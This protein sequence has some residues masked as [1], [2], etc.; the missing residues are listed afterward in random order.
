MFRS[1][2]SPFQ[3]RGTL[4]LLLVALIMTLF[5]SASPVFADGLP[6]ALL[7]VPT[8]T[9]VG[10]PYTFTVAFDNDNTATV[11][12][13]PYID[14]ALPAAGAD[15]AGAQLDDGITFTSAAYLG[16]PV[17]PVIPPF[18]CTGNFTHPL[19]GLV[20]ACVVDTQIVI[21]QPPYGS[22][23]PTQPP[24][25]LEIKTDL[26]NLADVGTPLT[27]RAS[28]GF[29]LGNDP[30]DNPVSDPPI[31]Q[32]TTATASVTPILWTLTKTY[33]GPESE[34]ATGPNFP[35]QYR[36]DIDIATG[37]VINNLDITDLLPPSMQFIGVDSVTTATGSPT[38]TD[39]ATPST[40]TPGGTL[41]R[42]LSSAAGTAGVQDAS[43]IFSFFVPRLDAAS[44]VI[45]PDVSGDDALGINDAQA[46]G[47]W[48]TADGRD[49][50]AVVAN[51]VTPTDHTLEEQSIA[52]QK[53]ANNR[54]DAVTSPGDL[55]QYTLDVQVSDYFAFQ[56]VR[57]DDTLGDGL[58]FDDS[59]PPT[60][61]CSEHGTTSTG[62][63][64]VANYTVADNWTDVNG[65]ALPNPG[66]PAPPHTLDPAANNGTTKLTFR[67]S[68]QLV[69]LG[70]N[71]QLVGGGIPNGGTGAGPLSNNP[72]LPF[73]PTTCQ[74]TYRATI[75]DRFTDVF[76]SNDFSID[77]GDILVNTAIVD[78]AV[79]AASNL[80]PT[81]QRED[82]DTAATISIARGDLSKTIYAINGDTA[83]LPGNCNGASETVLAPGE[84]VTYR[85]RLSL[86]TSDI[87]KLR[88]SDF[89]PLPIFNVNDNTA[90]IVSA[91]TTFDTT[92][93]PAPPPAGTAKFGPTDNFFAESGIQPNVIIDSLA[94]SVTFDY[95]NYDD[96]NNTPNQIDI[97]FTVTASYAPFDDKLLLTNLVREQETSTN[98]GPQVR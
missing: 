4:V 36:I 7:V 98:A 58:R 26:S 25:V 39:L 34:T 72:L 33:I 5:G 19:T 92:V 88:L 9:F 45:L 53:S 40:S 71:G 23:T 11:G 38:V 75:E 35:R 74:I 13:G 48:D 77:Q 89:L 96:V 97:L 43:L 91:I 27:I 12:Y 20:T 41:T 68:D 95:D 55:Y 42:R 85:L 2:P 18:L 1:I 22:F 80:V 15:G 82:D 84:T 60:L 57:V 65:A 46:N 37:Q 86:P 83:C 28:S 59:F 49:L 47:T 66:T 61:S 14:L 29:Y 56:D 70:A 31:I 6:Q 90:P 3:R 63:F 62:V 17:V 8:P 10:E 32:A 87:E 52:I 81:G 69:A 78:G 30:L 50:D 93:S 24:A 94:N 21:L 54:S 67:I 44:G 64:A 73:G 51:D 79:L 16:T 76:P